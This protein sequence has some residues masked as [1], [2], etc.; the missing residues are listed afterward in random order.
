MVGCLEWMLF[1]INAY[2]WY[3]LENKQRG[4]SNDRHQLFKPLTANHV[5]R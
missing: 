2:Q 4:F 5:G 1:K 3:S